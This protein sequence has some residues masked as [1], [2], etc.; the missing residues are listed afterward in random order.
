MLKK[1]DHHRQQVVS[2]LFT[3][4]GVDRFPARGVFRASPVFDCVAQIE[5]QLKV[6]ATP[7]VPAI[8]KRGVRRSPLVDKNE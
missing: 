3:G 6:T 5:C 8:K 7:R 4:K 2:V 1:I